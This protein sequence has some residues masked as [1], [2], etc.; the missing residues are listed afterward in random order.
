MYQEFT[1]QKGSTSVVI[2]VRIIDSSTLDS[3]TNTAGRGLTGLAFN[4]S[5]LTCYAM[6]QDDGN[7]AGTAVTLATATRGSFTSGGWIEKDGTNMT[8]EY[9]FGIPNA[10]IATGS[11][12][13]RFV[14]RGA[15]NMV[16]SVVHIHLVDETAKT[17]KDVADLTSG[18]TESYSTDGSTA[19]VAQMLYEIKSVLTEFAKSG[20]TLTCFKLDGTTTALT[21]TL[22]DGTNPT[23]VQRTG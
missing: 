14:F 16:E 1:I 3:T 23:L 20:T 2:P 9:E 15:S 21:L 13:C 12:W 4:T 10:A 11:A 22:D 17:V 8:G 7:N 5:S 6:R 18:Q 19:S